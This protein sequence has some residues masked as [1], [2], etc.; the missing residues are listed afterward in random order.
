MP[1]LSALPLLKVSKLTAHFASADVSVSAAIHKI[2]KAR[3]ARFND[4]ASVND[5]V[6]NS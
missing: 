5:S 6:L 2:V 3:G 4:I 1:A